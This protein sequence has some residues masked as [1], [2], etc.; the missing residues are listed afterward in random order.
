[1]SS[2]VSP[3]ARVAVQYAT[4]IVFLAVA[5]F[6]LYL[7]QKFTP[8]SVPVI[9]QSWEGYVVTSALATVTGFIVSRLMVPNRAIQPQGPNMM[10]IA[11]WAIITTFMTGIILFVMERLGFMQVFAL[12]PISFLTFGETLFLLF[13]GIWFL[14]FLFFSWI[15]LM[16]LKRTMP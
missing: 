2:P 9:L 1:M 3:K 15:V 14:W 13:F 8:G 7:M 10:R 5:N 6:T 12:Q 16:K 11:G 4:V